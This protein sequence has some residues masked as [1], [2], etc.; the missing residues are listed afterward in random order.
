R[1]RVPGSVRDDDVLAAVACWKDG[2]A[3]PPAVTRELVRRAASLG[4][5]VE[6]GCDARE[7]D[8]DVLVVCCGPWSAELA[9]ELPI[10]PL[11]R[12]LLETAP[13]EL[14]DDLPMVVEEE[15]GFHFRR[16][17]DRLVLAMSDPAPPSALD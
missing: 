9:P 15:S 5:R 12:Q 14:G 17:R 6:E 4:V 2:L 7:L 1:T 11:C 10:R 8:R 16:R 13:L 3:D